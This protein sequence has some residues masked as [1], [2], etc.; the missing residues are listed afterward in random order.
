MCCTNEI[1]IVTPGCAM[2][3]LIL[4][5]FIPGLGTAING[6]SGTVNCTLLVAGLL[7][8]ILAPVIIGWVWSIY[9]G[10]VILSKSKSHHGH[11]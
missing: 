9:F 10:C 4:N 8:F 2:I 7:Q 1:E 11:H 3:L 6:F 5:I